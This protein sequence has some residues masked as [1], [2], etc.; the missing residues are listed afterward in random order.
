MDNSSNSIYG[1][2][3]DRILNYAPYYDYKILVVQLL[4]INYYSYEI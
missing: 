4:F 2:T 3:W 1:V